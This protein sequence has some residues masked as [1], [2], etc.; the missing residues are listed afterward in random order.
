M[1]FFNL[2]ERKLIVRLPEVSP[3]QDLWPYE[4]WSKR[5]QEKNMSS[6]LQLK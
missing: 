5:F 2:E 6:F 3:E 4:R 1:V